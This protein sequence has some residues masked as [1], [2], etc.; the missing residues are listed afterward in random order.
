MLKKWLASLMTLMVL[1]SISLSV[2]AADV[3]PKPT[4]SIY[5]QDYAQVLTTEDK[6][7]INQWG[8]SLDEKTKAQLV[9]V[10]VNSLDG[11][12]I[13]DYSLALLRKWGIGDKEKNNGVLMLIAVAD[14]KSR[15]EVGYGLEGALPDGKTG[16]IQ[17]KFILPYFREGNYS[18]GIVN[19]YAALL[20]TTADEY[21][22]TLDDKVKAVQ[23][24]QTPQESKPFTFTD[25][26]LIIGL[27][28]LLIIDWTF[29]GG[30]LTRLLLIL[31]S[32]SR[33][34][35]G[36]GGGNYGGGSGGGGGS[37]R[38]W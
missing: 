7:K 29:F 4:N 22:V 8:K 14:K 34:G 27:V 5:V 10:T 21:A 20:K 23:G 33:G 19:G 1:L 2:F 31:I 32:R 36:G 17:D 28:I 6:A 16:E 25:Y 37:S 24:S 12:A 13:E 26:L 30:A 3:P 9:V 15:I 38:N 35:G 11:M 18:A